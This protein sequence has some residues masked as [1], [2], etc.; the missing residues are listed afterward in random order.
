MILAVGRNDRI[1]IASSGPRQFAGIAVDSYA[2]AG[3]NFLSYRVRR[4]ILTSSLDFG[5]RNAFADIRFTSIACP[6]A[7][8]I[9]NIRVGSLIAQLPPA[10]GG[11]IVRAPASACSFLPRAWP[12]G[13]DPTG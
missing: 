2:A 8:K 3:I 10:I 7:S 12:G 1:Y 9:A 11:R 13:L 5:G 6:I 4:G